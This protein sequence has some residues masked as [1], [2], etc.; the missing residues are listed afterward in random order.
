MPV[1]EAM[2][3]MFVTVALFVGTYSMFNAF[4]SHRREMAKIKYSRS[5]REAALLEDKV[6]LKE[7]VTMLQDRIAVLETIAT[8][9][10]RRTAEEIEKLR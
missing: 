9:P 10:A 8:D 1:Q 2:A 6:E 7:T 5:D 4:L 3:V